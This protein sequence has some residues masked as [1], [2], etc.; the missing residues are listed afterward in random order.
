[1]ELWMVT[2]GYWKKQ[3]WKFSMIIFLAFFLYNGVRNCLVE[4]LTYSVISMVVFRLPIL[5]ISRRW[6]FAIVIYS[7]TN[8]K[9]H[10][11]KSR[12]FPQHLAKLNV[13]SNVLSIWKTLQTGW[14]ASQIFKFNRL[15]KRTVIYIT[16]FIYM[17]RSENHNTW[18]P[19]VCLRMKG[20][21]V[22]EFVLVQHYYSNS[23]P[24]I[25]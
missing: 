6:K 13:L 23:L 5:R 9:Q 19:R 17:F 25:F 2:L 21:I 24:C 20:S 16:V 11:N 15:L 18:W 12:F 4:K 14:I 3:C 8:G 1:M 22:T 10:S 7:Y